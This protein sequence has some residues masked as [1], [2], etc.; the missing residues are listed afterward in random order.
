M[1]ANRIGSMGRNPRRGAPLHPETQSFADSIRSAMA[2]AG[3]TAAELAR[4]VQQE[5]PE[6]SPG[7]IS[8]YLSGRSVPRP[9]VLKAISHALGKNVEDFV[10]TRAP[11]NTGPEKALPDAA[12]VWGPSFALDVP[13]LNVL[14]LGD[15][16]AMLQINQKL[17]WSVALR[18]LQS[19]RGEGEGNGE[20]R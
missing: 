11:R 4:R 16:T 9:R 3:V 8:H 13:A 14:D 12:A 2:D 15:G 10:V 7:N 18:I 6:F 1:P 5:I 20:L 17:P 19:L